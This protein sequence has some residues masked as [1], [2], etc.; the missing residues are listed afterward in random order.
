MDAPQ[1]PYVYNAMIKRLRDKTQ[2][3]FKIHV[4]VYI[5]APFLLEELTFYIT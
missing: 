3:G 2:F 1:G 4:P 5:A